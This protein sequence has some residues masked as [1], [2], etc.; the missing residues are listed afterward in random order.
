MSIQIWPL[1]E[2]ETHAVRYDAA[3]ATI[4][5]ESRARHFFERFRG[6]VNKATACAFSEQQV[7]DYAANH[8][9]FES[10]GFAPIAAD[11][12]AIERWARDVVV[13]G[14]PAPNE[15]V[16]VLV[17]ISSMTRQLI[18]AVVFFLWRTAKSES[19]RISVHFVYSIAEFGPIPS[20]FGP[21]VSNGPSIQ[22]FAGWSENSRL[23]CGVILGVGYEEDLALGVI[24]DLEAA[25]VWLFRPKGGDPRYEEAVDAKNRGLFEEIASKNLIRYSVFDPYSVFVTVEALIGLS[26]RDCRLIIVPFG[27]KVFAL[28][29]CLAGLCHYPEVG[30]W[31]V[32]GGV[33]QEPV[34]RKPLG[35]VLG[36]AAV[37]S[38]KQ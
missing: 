14:P 6:N 10:R 16:R 28:S 32:S 2:N 23:P 36:L 8:A 18:A 1:L 9:F 3:L 31:R 26:K 25:R 11:V 13:K 19:R 29:S 35:T 34:D 12:S 5:Y 17:D 22:P 15:P 33:N 37:F 38:P 7:L 24:E 21:I 30:F 4:G 27:P 20:T